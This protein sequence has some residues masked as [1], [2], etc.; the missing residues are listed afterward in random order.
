MAKTVLQTINR[1]L[2]KAKVKA[3]GVELS[4]ALK[5]NCIEEL[6]DI[7]FQYAADGLHMGFSE[8]A[9]ETDLVTV[10]FWAQGFVANALATYICTEA[11]VM[12][13]QTLVMQYEESRRVVEKNLV[14]NPERYFDENVPSGGSDAGFWY[15]NAY[16][17]NQLEGALTTESGD[18][19]RNEE[20]EI[21]G[22]PN[23]PTGLN[24]YQ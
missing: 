9:E 3:L 24:P 10:P 13:S 22:K 14:N 17:G 8:V 21:I 1:A 20:G 12:P 7:M 5:Q 4:T 15:N 6:N 19:I 23:D 11:G 16:F 2:H 18:F